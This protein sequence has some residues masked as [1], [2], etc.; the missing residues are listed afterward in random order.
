MK[1]GFTLIELLAVIIILGI[2]LLIIVPNVAGILNRSQERLNEEQIREIE[3][4]AKQW[5]LRNLNIKN[6][7]PYKGGN[8]ISY[9]TID[10]L[11]KEGFLENKDVRDLTD[12]SDVSLNTKI[13]VSYDNNQFIYEYG[14]DC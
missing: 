5:G 12:N 3:S 2:I 11:Q 4:A 6:N 14:G 8:V 7:K 10:T 1:K 9:V 13:C